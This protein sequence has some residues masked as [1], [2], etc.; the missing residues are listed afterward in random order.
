MRYFHQ[1]PTEFTLKFSWQ[2][3]KRRAH[4]FRIEPMF[5]RFWFWKEGRLMDWEVAGQNGEGGAVKPPKRKGRKMRKWAVAL[6][7]IAVIV[8]VAQVS[9]CVKNQPKS[10]AWPSSGLAPLLPDPPPK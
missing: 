1:L 3:M 6:L 9:S 8:V 2:L 10:L 5:S 7:V 4:Q